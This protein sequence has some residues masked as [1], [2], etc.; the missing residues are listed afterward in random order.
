MRRI[1]EAQKAPAV[2]VDQNLLALDGDATA[3][4]DE[5]WDESLD[6]FLTWA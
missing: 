1:A 6:V 3:M 2:V 4:V 5:F